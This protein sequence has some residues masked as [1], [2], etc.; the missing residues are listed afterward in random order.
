MKIF[1]DKTKI[2]R[3]TLKYKNIGFVP[4]MGSLHNGHLSLIEKS[5]KQSNKTIV[6]IFINK[7]QFNKKNDFI[8][9]PRNLKKDIL[10]LKNLKVDILYLPYH[11]EIYPNGTNRNIKLNIFSKKLCGKF[12][13]LHFES[14][15]DV[16]ERFIKIIKPNRLYLGE[17]DFQQLLLIEDY[18]K[19]N[20]I[21]TKIIRCKT[22]R[23]NSGLAYSSRNL[24]LT[25]KEKDSASRVYKLIKK[26]KKNFL[27]K[28]TSASELRAEIIKLGI[29]K[30]EYLKILDINK[31]I[32]PHKR[33][34]KYKVFIAYFIRSVR[35]IDNI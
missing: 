19:L 9:Y 8:K 15:V 20:S 27:H 23:E 3:E 26:K 28:K 33:N 13:K 21:K 35:L 31:I 6:T 2:I 12:R 10:I 32:K 11:E 14:I 4:T 25:E 17:K 16:V 5:I 18:I 29:N 34:K 22:I 24:L 1:L 30:I 7:P